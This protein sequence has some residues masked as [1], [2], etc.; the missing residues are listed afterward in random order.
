MKMGPQARVLFYCEGCEPPNGR[1][2]QNASGLLIRGAQH[3]IRTMASKAFLCATRPCIYA[4]V[5]KQG[6]T[7]QNKTDLLPTGGSSPEELNRTGYVISSSNNCNPYRGMSRSFYAA[8]SSSFSLSPPVSVVLLYM[9][10]DSSFG[11]PFLLG[12]PELYC[13]RFAV[14]SVFAACRA[15][16][17]AYLVC[18]TLWTECV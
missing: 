11:A 9:Y 6:V 5:P 18:H 3:L 2:Q 8:I 15:G 7:L 14:V 10:I 13:I 4:L 17:N 16:P 1:E 12:Y